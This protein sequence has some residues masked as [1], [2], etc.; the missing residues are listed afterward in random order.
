MLSIGTTHFSMLPSL[1][2][3]LFWPLHDQSKI[4][5]SQTKTWTR[6]AL[7]ETLKEEMEKIETEGMNLGRKARNVV[8]WMM[9]PS[10]IVAV[11][12]NIFVLDARCASVEQLEL[13]GE[14]LLPM[15]ILQSE[16]LLSRLNVIVCL[17][18]CFTQKN[19]K[20]KVRD[21]PKEHPKTSF[22]PESDVE[23]WREFV[24]NVRPPKQPK[25]K[26]STAENS[27]EED[28]YEGPLKV[29]N[30]V[31][32]TC[33]KSFTAADE[34]RHKASA[35]FF[36]STALMGLLC[37]PKAVEAIVGFDEPVGADAL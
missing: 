25:G 1:T 29:P 13:L 20:Q 22:I 35:Q 37:R 12:V 3:T 16:W 7:Q 28:G 32:N 5:R 14:L 15:P 9:I 26:T 23:R 6:E 24:E 18:A 2:W 11:L 21:P 4:R 19:N 36:D 10:R 8:G 27:S 33:E 31:L 17:D 34:N 30:S